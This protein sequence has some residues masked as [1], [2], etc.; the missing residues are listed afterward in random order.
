MLAFIALAGF[1]VLKATAHTKFLNFGSNLGA[2]VV[3]VLYG[4]VLWKVG[5]LMGA[6]Q[7]AGAQVGSRFA[8]KNGAKIIKPL[9]VV[10]CIALA[11]RLLADPAHPLRVWLGW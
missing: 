9:L 5:L 4:A 7:F 10:T 2:F 3:F 8:M 1:G 6:G 11:I